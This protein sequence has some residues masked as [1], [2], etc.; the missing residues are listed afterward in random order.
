LDR[1]AAFAKTGGCPSLEKQLV[2]ADWEL[3]TN[4]NY[5]CFFEAKTRAEAYTALR[6]GFGFGR[7]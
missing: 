3:H 2:F 5:S 7:C 6:R 1:L 4:S